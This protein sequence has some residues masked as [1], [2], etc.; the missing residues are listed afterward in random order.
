MESLPTG[1]AGNMG[2]LHRRHP[3]QY[4]I[5]MEH[6]GQTGKVYQFPHT[7]PNIDVT[8]KIFV[9]MQN[10]PMDAHIFRLPNEFWDLVW[11]FCTRYLPVK[12]G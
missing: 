3:T 2:V 10:D 12:G 11:W 1:A 9:K 8:G 6:I 4:E 7:V 5:C